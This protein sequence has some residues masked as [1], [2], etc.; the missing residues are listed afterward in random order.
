[1]QAFPLQELKAVLKLHSEQLK[2][3]KKPL[4]SLQH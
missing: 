3:P 1:M 4:L 2:L